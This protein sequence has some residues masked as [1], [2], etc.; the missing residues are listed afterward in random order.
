MKKN[1]PLVA[2]AIAATMFGAAPSPLAQAQTQ[3]ASALDRIDTV[4]VIYAENRSFDSLYGNF[5][6]ANGLQHVTAAQYLQRDRD[7][8]VLRELPPIWTGLTAIG[9]T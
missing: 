9:L 4:V 2:A 1:L 5:P 8:S 6:G 7:G 3:R